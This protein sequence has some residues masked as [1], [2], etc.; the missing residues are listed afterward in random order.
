M[1][2]LKEFEL[3]TGFL[4]R[5]KWGLNAVG[6]HSPWTGPAFKFF[7]LVHTNLLISYAFKIYILSLYIWLCTLQFH[8]HSP[9]FYIN[10]FHYI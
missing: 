8:H 4:R 6:L 10:H 9:P 7:D 3:S 1:F 5:L 2:S